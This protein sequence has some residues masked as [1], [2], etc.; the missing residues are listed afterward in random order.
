MVKFRT[1]TVLALSLLIYC[2]IS[3]DDSVSEDSWVPIDSTVS[4]EWTDAQDL[5]FPLLQK[6]QEALLHAFNKETISIRAPYDLCMQQQGWA[7]LGMKYSVASSEVGIEIDEFLDAE[8]MPRKRKTELTAAFGTPFCAAPDAGSKVC[9]P[10]S[11]ISKVVY[12]ETCS[13]KFKYHSQSAKRS[14]AVALTCLIP[15]DN[16]VREDGSCQLDAM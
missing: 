12:T 3:C 10:E 15:R 14:F 11:N 4:M 7:F 5:C 6:S 1:S 8:I 2:C 9:S 16:S 13:W